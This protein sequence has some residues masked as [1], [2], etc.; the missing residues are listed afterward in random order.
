MKILSWNYRG[1]TRPAAVQNLRALIKANNPDVIF[2]SETKTSSF[3]VS[4]ILNH[5]GFYLMTHVTPIGT[6]GGLV[7]AW[8]VSVELKSFISNKNNI[9][10]WCYSDPPN[11][12]WILSCIYSPSKKKIKAAFWGSLTAVGKDFVS[13]WLCI[14]DFNFVLDQSKKLGGCLVASSSHYPLKNLIDHHGLVDLRFFGN[15]YTWC[16]N[17]QG[18]AIIKERLD[19]AFAS[20]DWVH[21]QPEFSFIHLSASIFYHNPVFLNTNTSSSFLPRCFKFEEF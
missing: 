12:P 13:P 7:F 17:R 8:K 15:P 14:G 16:N 18:L 20:L 10:S 5:L 1:I 4:P 21:I 19:R 2:L 3:L 9:T 11:S 6:C